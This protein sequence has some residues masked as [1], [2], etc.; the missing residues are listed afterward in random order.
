MEREQQMRD[1]AGSSGEAVRGA[2]CPRE[3]PV[4]PE[5]VSDDSVSGTGHKRRVTEVFWSRRER[6][7]FAASMDGAGSRG[8]SEVGGGATTIPW[9]ASVA[10]C[11]N[12]DGRAGRTTCDGAAT[13]KDRARMRSVS[14]VE[15][16]SFVCMHACVLYHICVSQEMVRRHGQPDDEVLLRGRVILVPE[17]V[18]SLPLRGS[19]GLQIFVFAAR[20][21]MW[22]VPRLRASFRLRS[23]SNIVRCSNCLSKSGES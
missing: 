2:A 9:K 15:R 16:A 10:A 23:R 6:I 21:R 11:A 7:R 19:L 20:A 12:R 8:A 17:R 18:W 1:S 22:P 5:I 4:T 14:D 13:C 3:P